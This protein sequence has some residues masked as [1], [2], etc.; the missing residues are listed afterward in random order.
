MS[1]CKTAGD[2]VVHVLNRR[3]EAAESECAELHDALDA[4]RMIIDE[5]Q[6]KQRQKTQAEAWDQ[7]AALVAASAG[8]YENADEDP[9]CMCDGISHRQDCHLWV[10]P[11]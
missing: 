1:C 2:H 4:I 6:A 8:L 3:A 7:L 11:Y 9:N 5:V 10:L